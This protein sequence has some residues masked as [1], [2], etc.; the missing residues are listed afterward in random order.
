MT[1]T[2]TKE[3]ENSLNDPEEPFTSEVEEAAVGVT[4][5]LQNVLKSSVGTRS[6]DA[7]STPVDVSSTKVIVNYFFQ[8]KVAHNAYT[9]NEIDLLG[10]GWS[11]MVMSQVSN[12]KKM[13]FEQRRADLTQNKQLNCYLNGILV[14]ECSS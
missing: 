12:F 4:G 9:I 14:C 6:Q 13:D 11:F 3:L 2:A 8:A 7:E 5:V 1:E 10:K